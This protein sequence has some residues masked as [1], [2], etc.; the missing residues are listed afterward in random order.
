MPL[1]PTPPPPP[2]RPPSTPVGILK[3][4][5]EEVESIRTKHSK[6]LQNVQ[7]NYQLEINLSCFL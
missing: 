1:H 2:Q 3:L 6:E 4:T 5:V 7:E